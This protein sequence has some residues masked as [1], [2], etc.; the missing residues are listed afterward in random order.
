MLTEK[1]IKA[2]KPRLKPYKLSDGL[3]LYVEVTPIGTK[4]W[5]QKYRFHGKEKRLSFGV[6]PEVSITTARARRDEAR[7]QLSNGIDPAEVRKTAKLAAVTIAKNSF[8]ML[9]LEWVQ[10]RGRGWGPK[11][12]KKIDWILG[13]NLFPWIGSRPISEITSPEL[14]MALRKIEARGA[15]ETAR[16]TKQIA[17][18]VFRFAI[19]TGRA[20]SD[21][22]Q[23]LK[24]ALTV[25]VIKHRA[26]IT[27]PK[28]VGPFLRMLHGYKG[29]H[30]VRAA[31]QLSP[32]LFVRPVELRQA[33]WA[34]ID[35]E[36]KIW[37]IPGSRMKMGKDHIVPLCKQAIEIFEDLYRISGR[38]E[39]VFIGVKSKKKSISDNTVLAALRSMGI[40]KETMCGHGFRAMART[41]LD[42]VLG[43]R[44]DI[45]EHQ[46]SH[47]VK[48]ANGRAY[49]RSTHLGERHKMMQLWA[50][51]LDKLRNELEVN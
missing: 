32:L 33:R 50:D 49:N 36:N 35:F 46:I 16:K 28:E 41:I 37:H 2:A 9:A 1:A 34:D 42:E 15:F 12:R 47:A 45:I 18:L 24:E 8:E 25:P 39:W 17:G 31:L 11:Y 21:P 27:N 44:P 10:V 13:K 19:S 29:T 43:I 20:L 3:G 14:L 22:S 7:V 4:L 23:S 40:P 26:A 5:R 6:Y 51:Y 38:Y 48:D 30:V